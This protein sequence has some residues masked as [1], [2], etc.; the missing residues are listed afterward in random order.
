MLSAVIVEDEILASERLR[1]LLNDC[2]ITLLATFQQASLALEWFK[3]HSADIV[4]VDINLPEMDGL[5]FVEK[6]THT[7]NVM[8]AVIFTTA[9]EEHA[10]KAFDL[11]ATDYLLKPIKLSRLKDALMRI[12]SKDSDDSHQEIDYFNI[13]NHDKMLRIPWQKVT[14]LMAD[15]K[16]VWLHT[17]D[18]QVYELLKTLIYWEEVLGD[19]VLRIHRNTLVMR[20]ALHSIVR[21]SSDDDDENV[22]WGAKIADSDEILPIS[23]RQLAILRR[24]KG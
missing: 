5:L 15:Q 3:N 20:H 4:F 12:Q 8:P 9:H 17:Y 14:Y 24:E 2:N 18:G 7:A 23:R 11:A 6:L 21:L 22:R 1:I 13:I 16:S 19:K 10:L